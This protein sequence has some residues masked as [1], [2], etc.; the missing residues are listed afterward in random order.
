MAS[1]QRQFLPAQAK[2]FSKFDSILHTSSETAARLAAKASV[3]V[4][5]PV[6]MPLL[7]A[8]ATLP[9]KYSFG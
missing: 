6:T 1:N 7:D 3:T 8:L 9:W 5:G 2:I 4:W